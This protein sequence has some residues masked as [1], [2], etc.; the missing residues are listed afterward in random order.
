[1]WKVNDNKRVEGIGVVSAIREMEEGIGQYIPIVI[2]Y[3]CPFIYQFVIV[4]H[5]NEIAVEIEMSV[6]Q[7]W[8]IVEKSHAHK[9]TFE[10]KHT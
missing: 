8:L 4:P 9:H 6:Q 10:T 1:M 3:L 2:L 7:L 5:L